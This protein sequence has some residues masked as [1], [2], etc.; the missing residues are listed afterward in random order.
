M[1]KLSFFGAIKGRDDVEYFHGMQEGK[2]DA[3]AASQ[4]ITFYSV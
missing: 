2:A 4:L 3:A 1:G